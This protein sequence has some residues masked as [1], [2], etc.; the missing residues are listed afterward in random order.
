MI[1]TVSLN[2]AID[3]TYHAQTLMMGQVNRLLSRVDIPG[4]KAINVTKVLKQFGA[5]VRASGFLGG[6]P[7]EFIECALDEMGVETDF[8]HIR[9]E[10]RVNMNIVGEDGYV[11]ELLEPGPKIAPFE[12][13]QFVAGFSGLAK[14]AEYICMSGSLTEG[15]PEDY[16]AQLIEIS[17]KCGSKVFLDTSGEPL[18]KGIEA[19]PYLIKPNRREL[20]YIVGHRLRTESELITASY[21][22]IKQ[23]VERV[24]VSMG[25]KGLLQITKN[26]VIKAVPPRVQAVNTVGCGDCVV[27]ALVLSLKQDFADEDAMRFAAGLSAANA[28]TLESGV[29]PEDKLDEICAKVAL[30]SM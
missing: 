9:N 26:K 11:T 17:N 10:T 12:R 8:L 27:A 22:F 16:Y 23:G 25:D 1:L 24:V 19:K 13:D 30:V 15:L 5:N 14:Q 2:P 6:Y 21:E 4:G 29:I 28:T 18:K 3:R 20:E 7:G